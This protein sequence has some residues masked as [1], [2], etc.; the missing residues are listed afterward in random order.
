MIV[1]YQD[2]QN[3]GQQLQNYALTCKLRQLGAQPCTL[4][5]SVR[6]LTSLAERRGALAP[7]RTRYIPTTP[8]LYTARELRCAL[9]G[10]R[11]ALFGGDQI[12]RNGRGLPDP[13]QPVL[14]F[15]GD[16]VAGRIT[17]ASYAASFG[18]DHF[19]GDEHL[20]ACC[21]ALLRRFDR[22]SVRERSGVEILAGTFGVEGIE[23]LDPVFLHDDR[24]YAQLIA[25]ADTGTAFATAGCTAYFSL[26]RPQLTASLVQRCPDGRLVN[27]HSNAEGRMPSV[28]QWLDAIR[29]ARAVITDSFHC[30]AFCIIFRTPFTALRT[31]ERGDARM[32]H[33]LARC[34][35]SS[36]LLNSPEELSSDDFAPASDWRGAET[37][38]STMRPLSERYLQEVLDIEPGY[39]VP[40]LL[41]PS[42]ARL[43]HD[44]ERVYER[45][46]RVQHLHERLL[47]TAGRSRGRSR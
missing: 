1:T 44:Y 24:H 11:A 12:F 43:R 13:Y 21:R 29:Q 36:R 17:L 45:Y 30:V 34:A 18:I 35:M 28:E 38:L 47:S 3:Y 42:L 40:Y 6:N 5:W 31:A 2:G 39:K 33:L 7:F 19:E 9:A 16:F 20:I 25:A 4:S 23:V 27:I 10:C 22:L 32:E 26:D 37:Y 46:R 14:R 15:Y 41:E 8:P